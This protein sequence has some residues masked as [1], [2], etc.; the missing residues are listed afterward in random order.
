MHLDVVDVCWPTIDS[1]VSYDYDGH[2]TIGWLLCIDDIV[3]R[4]C[5]V[6]KSPDIGERME[7]SL[8]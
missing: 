8:L 4:F 3:R 5:N 7:D 6:Y 1:L 2:E